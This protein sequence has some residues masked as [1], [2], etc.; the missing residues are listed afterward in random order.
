[1]TIIVGMVDPDRR[2]HI[3]ADSGATDGWEDS[4]RIDAKVFRNGAYLIGFT[5]S[6]RMGQLLHHA[7]T[8]PPPPAA[9]LDAFMATTFID[10]VRECLKSGGWSKKENEREEGGEFLVG[11][12]GRLFN[13]GSDYQV[14]EHACGYDAVGNGYLAALGAMFATQH[15]AVLPRARVSWALRAAAAHTRAVRPP[16][17]VL[18]VTP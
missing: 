1:M 2:V 13:V 5:T 14:G 11:V 12:A 17:R 16:F 4:T 3:G 18:S 7:L 10:A 6:F 15:I 9:R 8:P